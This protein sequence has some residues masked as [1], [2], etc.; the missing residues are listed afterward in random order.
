MS[1]YRKLFS[2]AVRALPVAAA[3]LS[4]ACLA[5]VDDSVTP[6]LAEAPIVGAT[7][8]AAIGG[9]VKIT[10]NG[11]ADTHTGFL[12]APNLVLTSK[13]WMDWS[14]APGTVTVVGGA[15]SF[16]PQSRVGSW[17]NSSNRHAAALIQLAPFTG[18][19]ARVLPIDTR[20]SSNLTGLVVRCYEHVGDFLQYA[21]MRITAANGDDLTLSPSFGTTESADAGAPCFDLSTWTAVAMVTPSVGATPHAF[22]IAGMQPWTEGMKNLAAARSSLNATRLSLYT[23]APNGQRMCLD[24]PDASPLDGSAINVYPCHYGPTERFW[25]DYRADAN[26]PRLVSDVS[27][28]C[29]DMPNASLASGSNY[30]QYGCH[31]GWNQRFELS[32]WNSGSGGWKLM[33]SHAPAQ[34][35]CLSV[36]GGP[37][38][39]PHPTEQRTCTG[40]A[41]QRWFPVW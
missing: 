41:D 27:G 19:S 38:A 13:N 40:S 23:I 37:T 29:A 2:R 31:L 9:I 35:L 15:G 32:L 33:P 8:P 28:R 7:N 3:A 34:N 24:I 10:V 14:T 4:G 25:L 20:A 22:R 11:Q 6:E 39:T 16:A 12:I 36:E 18:D 21:D 1:L 17:I 30:Q 26:R 5:D